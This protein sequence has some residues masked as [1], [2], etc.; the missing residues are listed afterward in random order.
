MYDDNDGYVKDRSP[1]PY[2]NITGIWEFAPDE[3]NPTL[4]VMTRIQ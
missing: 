4:L 3:E 1:V 2:E